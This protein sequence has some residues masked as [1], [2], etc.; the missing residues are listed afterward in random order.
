MPALL[1]KQI[2]LDDSTVDDDGNG[3][4]ASMIK[5]LTEL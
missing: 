4:I 2:Q 5:N 3:E 1:N